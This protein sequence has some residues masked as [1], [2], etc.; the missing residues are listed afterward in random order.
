MNIQEWSEA[1]DISKPVMTAA[2]LGSFVREN[3]KDEV[4]ITLES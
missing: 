3:K 1:V 2:S 4:T